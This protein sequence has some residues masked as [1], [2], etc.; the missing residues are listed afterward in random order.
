MSR[1]YNKRPDKVQK[2]MQRDANNRRNRI[3]NRFEELSNDE[4]STW[5]LESSDSISSR[6][7]VACNGEEERSRVFGCEL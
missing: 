4:S 2:A 3:V 1:S 5:F 6:A 7:S